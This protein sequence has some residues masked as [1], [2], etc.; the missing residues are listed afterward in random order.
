[1]PHFET[2]NLTALVSRIQGRV[3]FLGCRT[4]RERQR[5]TAAGHGQPARPSS[6]ISCVSSACDSACHGAGAH[7]TS[8]KRNT[9]PQKTAQT[10]QRGAHARACTRT[11][12]D[13][14]HVHA[15]TQTCT[16]THTQAS[17]S[18]GP[19]L[20]QAPCSA[21]PPAPQAAPG[22]PRRPWRPCAPSL[23]VPLQAEPQDRAWL[24]EVQAPWTVKVR[25][26]RPSQTLAD[27]G[28]RGAPGSIP[29]CSRAA[30]GS[31]CVDPASTASLLCC[32]QEPTTCPPRRPFLHLHTRGEAILSQSPWAQRR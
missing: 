5:C 12:A 8:L 16:H 10:G 11:L 6:G 17:S 2:N 15:H 13:G 9:Q 14:A 20:G 28:Q 29:A 22:A 32:H 18:R 7:Q 3:R 19:A 24:C 1:M 4:D 27:D 25:G 31:A 26:T 21:P 23:P 30:E